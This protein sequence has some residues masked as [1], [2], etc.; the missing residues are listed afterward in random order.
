MNCGISERPPPR[1]PAFAGRLLSLVCVLLLALAFAAGPAGAYRCGLA[2][3]ARTLSA[4]V[5]QSDENCP[6]PRMKRRTADPMSFAF[7]VGIIVAVLLVPIAAGRSRLESEWADP[8][9]RTDARSERERP[10]KREDPPPE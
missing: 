7:F 2:T 8:S 6:A 5:A 3:S 9:F 10:G 4:H 1:R